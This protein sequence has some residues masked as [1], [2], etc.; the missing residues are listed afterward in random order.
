[1]AKNILLVEDEPALAEAIMLNL[2]LEGYSATLKTNGT[3]AIEYIFNNQNKI[4]LI[5][6]DVMI[7]EKDGL[8]VSYLIRKRGLK[9]PILFLSARNSTFDKI[10]GLKAGGNDYLGKPFDLEEFLLRVQ[11]LTAIPVATEEQLED[12]QF[13]RNKINFKNFVGTNYNGDEI[14][15]T[16]KEM[17]ILNIFAAQPNVVV[18]REN[19]AA[20]FS[21]QENFNVRSI[22]NAIVKFRKFFNDKG[23]KKEH[24]LSIRGVGYMFKPESAD[25]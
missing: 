1:M 9:T 15:F 10:Q 13:G 7:P 18:K 21:S 23:E 8:E 3:D 4:E 20:S 17:T 25:T 2:R 5:I 6:L 22:D 11:I 14:S 16:K 24:F 19:I 12:L